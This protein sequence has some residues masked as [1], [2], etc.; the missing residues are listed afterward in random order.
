MDRGKISI[1]SK[2]PASTI[3][4]VVVS[5]VI[6]IV[7]FGIAMMIY[8]NVMRMSLS[9]KKVRAE[10]ILQEQMLKTRMSGKAAEQVV[11]LEDF[12]IEQDIKQV[13]GEPGLSEV[14]LTAFD[15][16]NLQTARVMEIIITP[17]DAR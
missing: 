12:R 10:A 8:T 17:T 16:N 2:L 14:T 3:P 7:V 1:N 9:V 11:K 13:D 15:E 4:E 5:M 6:I